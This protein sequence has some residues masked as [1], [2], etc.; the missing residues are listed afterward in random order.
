MNK[1]G[2]E[3]NTKEQHF[4]CFAHIINLGVQDTFKLLQLKPQIF[5][6]DDDG[7][8]EE[9]PIHANLSSVSKL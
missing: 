8:E 1:C 3:F 5:V 9:E 4:R 7:E 6:D 2:I